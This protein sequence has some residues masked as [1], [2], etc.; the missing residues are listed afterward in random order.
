[1]GWWFKLQVTGFVNVGGAFW[2]TARGFGGARRASASEMKSNTSPSVLS[3]KVEKK[4][5]MCARRAQSRMDL[6]IL[7]N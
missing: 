6:S 4:Q 2:F 1:M 3:R 5:I 7:W